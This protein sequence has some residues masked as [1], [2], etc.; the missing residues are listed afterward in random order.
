MW[1]EF[2]TNLKQICEWTANL[3]RQ[4]STKLSKKSK[5]G[6]FDGI[7]KSNN[8]LVSFK[9]NLMK[10]SCFNKKLYSFKIFLWRYIFHV[11]NDK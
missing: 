1:N 3:S 5:I 4:L 11:S 7:S 8:E 10:K 2:E 9:S 6:Q